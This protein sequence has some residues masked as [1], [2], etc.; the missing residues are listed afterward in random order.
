MDT[1]TFVEEFGELV[2]ELYSK[3]PQCGDIESLSKFAKYL[4]QKSDIDPDFIQKFRFLLRERNKIINPPRLF[5][6]SLTPE[7]IE[8]LNE[9]NQKAEEL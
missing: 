6:I 7:V 9:I 1:V 8:L 4:E 3:F 5:K 2:E